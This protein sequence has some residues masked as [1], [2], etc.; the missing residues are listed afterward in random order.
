MRPYDWVKNA[1]KK[2]GTETTASTYGVTV[3]FKGSLREMWNGFIGIWKDPDGDADGVTEQIE[4]ADSDGDDRSKFVDWN[5]NQITL[6]ILKK[7]STVGSGA[8]CICIVY[9]CVPVSH[10]EEMQARP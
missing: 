3:T 1:T 4:E 8:D 10:R 2:S 5:F 9:L 6:Q 7:G